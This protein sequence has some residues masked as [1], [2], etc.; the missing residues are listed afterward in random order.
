MFYVYVIKC[1]KSGKIYIGQTNNIS[2]R[3]KRHNLKLPIKKKSYTFINKGP[4]KLVYKE[5]FQSRKEAKAR[6]K[7]LKS[8]KGREYI[9]S[10]IN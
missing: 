4:W 2:N 1:A 3:L 10:I 7:Q 6:E 9:K 5:N 8:Y